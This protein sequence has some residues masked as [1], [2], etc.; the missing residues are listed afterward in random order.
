MAVEEIEE[1]PSLLSNLI[2]FGATA[3]IVYF[4][5]RY[6]QGTLNIP[7][8]LPGIVPDAGSSTISTDTTTA[9]LPVPNQNLTPGINYNNP[10]NIQDVILNNWVGKIGTYTLPSGTYV[11][12]DTP[13]NG[14]RA[15]FKILKSY[16]SEIQGPFTIYAIS[17]LWSADNKDAWAATVAQ[18]AGMGLNDPVDITNPN[19][20]VALAEGITAIEQ[21]TAWVDYWGQ[22]AI[23]AGFQAA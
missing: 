8:L 14:Y 19:Q 13:A 1:G 3:G 2:F 6:F 16:Q 23:V 21:G 17:R 10:G 5:I 7:V 22:D 20:M 4:G 12:F 18:Y 9:I 15:I 11:I